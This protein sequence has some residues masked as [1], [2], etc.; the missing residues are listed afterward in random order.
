MDQTPG[1]TF[2]S[3]PSLAALWPPAGWQG[4]GFSTGM[5]AR[6]VEAWVKQAIVRHQALSDLG[7][8]SL[9]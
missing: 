5:T 4:C 7:R 3:A 9:W 8:D 2:A 1:N 6:A